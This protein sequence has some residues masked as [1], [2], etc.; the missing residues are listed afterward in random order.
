[1]E[2]LS[3]F[4]V[5]QT[6]QSLPCSILEIP[7]AGLDGCLRMLQACFRK[8]MFGAAYKVRTLPSPSITHPETAAKMVAPSFYTFLAAVAVALFAE[9]A[10]AGTVRISPESQFGERRR[11]YLKVHL[12]VDY[13]LL[14]SKFCHSINFL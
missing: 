6:A 4:S 10:R 2:E 11:Q 1:M 9:H 3:Q 14:T 13:L 5:D 7:H 12:V 8:Q